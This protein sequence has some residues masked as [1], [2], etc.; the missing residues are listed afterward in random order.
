MGFMDIKRV[1]VLGVGISVL[2]L[3]TAVAAVAEAVRE[4]RKGYICVRDAH[5]VMLAQEDPGFRRILNEAFLCTPDGMPMVWMGKLRG[6]REMS[7]VY[8]PDLMLEICAWSEK[9]PCRHFL[10][11]GVP[12]VAEELRDRLTARFPKL[13]IVGCYTPPFRPLNAEEEKT[14]QELVHAAQPDIMWIGLSTPKQEKFMVEF[15][16]KL[17]VT[18]MIGVGAAFDFHAGRARQAPRWMQRSGLEWF[19]RMVTEPRRLGRRYLKNTPLF[20]WKLAG[21]LAGLKKYP[22]E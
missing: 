20:A 5:G 12:G 9:N 3:P 14:L 18:L 10:Y 22:L 2:N 15:L 6:H 13:Q 17:E 8:G 4:R 7:R 19:F 16:P 21:Q 11:G 1:N